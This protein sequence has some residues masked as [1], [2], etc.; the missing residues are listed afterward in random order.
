MKRLSLCLI[1]IILIAVSALEAVEYEK[2]PYRSMVYSAV[3]PGG[4]QIY[5]K[6]YVKAALII[7]VQS[8]LIGQAI[9]DNNKMNKYKDLM[10][11]SNSSADL[12]NRQKRDKFQKD[13]RSDYWWI[14]TSLFL[15][16]ADAFVDA[17]LYNFNS[18]KK[19]VHLKFED[20]LL[21]LEYKF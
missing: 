4:G 1:M 10:D 3:V 11:G 18:E 17:H 12:Y 13:L 15:S 7:G 20:K 16:I 19:K 6:R 9:Y 14:G 21:K 2:N 5:T 8:A